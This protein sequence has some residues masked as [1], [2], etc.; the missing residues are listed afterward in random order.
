M[1]YE[2]PLTLTHQCTTHS[3]FPIL[4]GGKKNLN[5]Q[6]APRHPTGS[7]SFSSLFVA[8]CTAPPHNPSFAQP[9]RRSTLRPPHTV[10]HVYSMNCNANI[11]PAIITSMMLTTK[12]Q[13]LLVALVCHNPSFKRD[14]AERGRCVGRLTRAISRSF[15]CE[16]V[17]CSSTG[18]VTP[19][20]HSAMESIKQGMIKTINKPPPA[21]V[22]RK[23][24]PTLGYQIAKA[25]VMDMHTVDTV[26]MA[27]YGGY[28]LNPTKP[29]TS[30]RMITNKIGNTVNNCMNKAQLAMKAHTSL[31][32]NMARKDWQLEL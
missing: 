15:W 14:S 20:W 27:A 2:M 12:R 25:S 28:F 18:P 9:H 16:T 8:R 17:L 1:R 7:P 13:F 24:S 4:C 29:N 32:S 10:V 31:G 11:P 5:E 6:L 22:N 30:D 23:T 26:A 19:R 21:P 3:L